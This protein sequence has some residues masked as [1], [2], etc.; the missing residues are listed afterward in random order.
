MSI[1]VVAAIEDAVDPGLLASDGAEVIG[2]NQVGEIELDLSRPIAIDPYT[3]DPN[4]GRIVLE[5][6]G[7]IAGGGLILTAQ[8]AAAGTAAVPRP[9]RS[10]QQRGRRAQASTPTNCD[11]RPPRWH[12][13]SRRLSPAERIAHLRR[14]VAGKIVFTTSFG[15][16]DQVILHL[17]S[18]RAVSTSTW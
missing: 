5:F 3:A 2:Q 14:E 16:E 18:E 4:T 11:P 12:K 1:A 7:R 10:R 13:C 6:E 9:A 15:L 8:A 17:L